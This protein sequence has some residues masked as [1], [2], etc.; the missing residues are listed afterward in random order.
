MAVLQIEAGPLYERIA[1]ATTRTVVNYGGTRSGKTYTLLQYLIIQAV[2]DPKPRTVSIVRKTLP[3]LKI[4]A[5]RDFMEILENLNLYDVANHNKS[6]STY[7]LNN[8]LFEFIS[9]DNA[10]K[11]KGAKRDILFINEANELSY[12]DFFQLNVRTTE[13]VY[14]DWNPSTLFWAND[15]VLPD[16]DT[17]II[18]STYKDNPFLPQMQIDEIEKLRDIDPVLWKVYGEGEYAGGLELIYSHT[19]IDGIDTKKIEDGDIKFVAM[20]MDFGFTNDPTTLVEVYKDDNNL[21]VNELLYDRNLTNQDIVEKIR[22]LGIDKY[23]HIVADSA[24]PKSIEEIHRQ[25]VNIHPAKKGPDSIKN[26]IDI[27]KRYKLHVTAT[28][29]NLLRELNNYKWITD[30][31]GNTL[32]KPVAAFDHALDALRY[33]A[34]NKLSEGV[35]KGRY[36]IGIIG[37]SAYR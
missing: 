21:Y 20:G 3:A 10:E 8:T 19:V 31:D 27:L 24:E 26:G 1:A 36:R 14:L 15:K 9:I 5:Y 37:N 17:T 6:D 28:S 11:R 34:L 23:T 4:T 25:G 7:K 16:K 30:K 32:N 35:P 22:G 18:K 29:T 12:I 13:K 2:A 33:V